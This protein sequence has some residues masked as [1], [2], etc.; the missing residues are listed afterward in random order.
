M[1]STILTLSLIAGTALS[2]L[3]TPVLA[4]DKDPLAG[5][6]VKDNSVPGQQRQFGGS[7]ARQKGEARPLPPGAFMRALASLESSDAPANVALTEEQRTKIAQIRSEFE[8][9]IK[10]YKD[11]HADEIQKVR[12]ALPAPE[13][14]RIDDFLRGPRGGE[15]QGKGERGPKDRPEGDQPPPPPPHEGDMMNDDAKPSAEVEAARAKARELLEGAPKP[16]DA[17]QQVMAILT[18]AQKSHVKAE[19]DKLEKERSERREGK[20]GPEGR[21][22]PEGERPGAAIMEKLTQEERDSLKNMK[23]EERREFLRKKAQELGITP[24]K[25]KG[26]KQPK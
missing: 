5:P 14:R 19:L 11:Q 12:D 4:Q 3:A 8:A 24:G 21:G 9:K 1:R 7:V 20:G 16:A 23:P 22:G 10:A 26:G 25:G 6:K 15:G 2:A 13:Q 17:Q 18:E